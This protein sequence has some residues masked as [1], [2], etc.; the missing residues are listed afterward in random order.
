MKENDTSIKAISERLIE[1][2]TFS[3]YTTKQM[4]DLLDLEESVYCRYEEGNDEVPINVIYKIASI[5]ETEPSYILNGLMP[6]NDE[7]VQVFEGKGVSIKRYEG[8]SFSSLAANFKN[9][10]MN[11]MLVTLSPTDTPELVVHGGQEF[12]YVLEGEL[13]VIVGSKDY[14]LRAGDSLYFNPSLPHAQLPMNNKP[15]KFLTVITEL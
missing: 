12:N 14:Y 9:K 2:R 7:A 8:Y 13:R 3:D 15:A 6:D 11:P 1:L 5:L 4:A 10:V